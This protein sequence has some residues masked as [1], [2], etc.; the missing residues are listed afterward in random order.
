[1]RLI[2]RRSVLRGT[3]LGSLAVV[4]TS[5]PSHAAIAEKLSVPASDGDIALTRYGADGEGK[6]AAVVLLHGARGIE[7]KPRAYERYANALAAEGIDAYLIRYYSPADDLA[8]EKITTSEDRQAYQ[9]GRHDGWI[10][11]VSSAVTTILARPEGNGRLGLLGFSLG[12]F[13]A[14]ATAARD[15]RVAALAVLYGGMPDKIA[16][17]VKHLPPLLE[18][19][20]DADRNVPFARGEALVK[21]AKA[22]GGEAELVTYPGKGHAFDFS[23]T[24][25][26]TADAVGRVVRFFQSRLKA[27]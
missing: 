27:A 8:L 4:A 21:L 18:L 9:A 15:D 3:V 22:T 13:V 19:H 5:R 10:A 6:R 11:R 1:M 26:M 14:A 12:G 2:S 17:Q 7:L 16:P 20:G 24:D 23:D 25:P